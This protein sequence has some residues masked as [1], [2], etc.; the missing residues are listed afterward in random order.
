MKIGILTYG[1]IANFGANLQC[2]STYMYLLK[3]G[4]TPIYIYYLS[5]ELYQQIEHRR[6]VNPQ[7]Q[8]HYDYFDS[9]VKNRTTLCHSP[10]DINNAIELNAIEA[11]IIGADAVLQ[12]HP[13][14]SRLHVRKSPKLLRI[15]RV[16]SD[17]L[18]PNLFW[19]YGINEDVRMVMMSVS[20]QNSEYRY[21]I[22]TIRKKMKQAL[23]RFAYISVRDSWTQKMIGYIDKEISVSITP[24]PVFAFN[25]NLGDFIPS[26]NGLLKKYG[27]PDKYVLI[28]MFRQSLKKSCL[29][30]LKV[31]FA[32][33]G[34][35]CVVLPMPEGVNF[36][37]S[38]QY[39]V[40]SPLSPIDWYALIKYSK[41][42]IGENMHPIVSC[43]HNAVP[44]YS[45]DNWGTIDFFRR[46]KND[47]SSK[48]E[49]I[50]KIFGVEKNRAPI[51]EGT[52]NVSSKEIVDAIESF[53][54]KD[55]EQMSIQYH[56]KY[57]AMMD[58]ILSIINVR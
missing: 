22:P 31:C 10:E 3:H 9:I 27:L 23:K 26:K 17:R 54:F 47:G 58:E 43:L 42:Y 40:S 35:A 25:Y 13:F 21:F 51:S 24:D 4:H 11:V 52:C 57:L 12:H 36:E 2:T 33:K 53:P 8:A 32:Q 37:H 20:C 19:G 18:F 45:I 16:T 28:S 7:I 56:D 6:K 46:K 15:D 39:V 30:E 50:L 38:F 44:C 34:I 29:D 5:K 1:R 14:L 41:G 48:V 49:D 55:V